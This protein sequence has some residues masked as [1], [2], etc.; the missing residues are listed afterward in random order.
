MDDPVI[1]CVSY[2][3][4]KTCITLGKFLE[5][6][7]ERL[8][9]LLGLAFILVAC[10]TIIRIPGVIDGLLNG[11]GKLRWRWKYVGI[12]QLLI[13]I[14]DLPLIISLPFYILC[15]WR[16]YL[17]NAGIVKHNEFEKYRWEGWEVRGRILKH[18]ILLLF[19]ILS[20]PFAICLTVSWRCIRCFNLFSKCD[21]KEKTVK[22]LIVCQFLHL[23]CDI[24]ALPFVVI[25]MLS[26][27]APIILKKIKKIY[28]A[29]SEVSNNHQ[30]PKMVEL[31]LEEQHKVSNI[32][33]DPEVTQLESEKLEGN[34]SE[35]TPLELEEQIP[36]V[37]QLELQEELQEPNEDVE[38]ANEVD[39]K[40]KVVVIKQTWSLVLD[41]SSVPAMITTIFSWR[42][43]FFLS[44]CTKKFTTRNLSLNKTYSY[45]RWK[46]WQNLVY[47]FMDLPCIVSFF[48]LVVFFPI[49]PWRLVQ[50]LSGFKSRLLVGQDGKEYK[51]SK[52]CQM[53]ERKLLI[54]AY[55]VIACDIA[56]IFLTIAIT[57]SLWR[58]PFLVYDLRKV[59]KE[60]LKADEGTISRQYGFKKSLK[61]WTVCVTNFVLLFADLLCIVIGLIIIGTLWR[62]YSLFSSIR[63]SLSPK[64][65]DDDKEDLRITEN[66][67][68]FTVNGIKIRKNVFKHF[69]FLILDIPALVLCFI[70]I[71]F[72]IKIPAIISVVLGGNFYLEFAVTVYIETAKLFAD[73]VFFFIFI[74]M[75]FT[76]PIAIWVNVLEDKK[77]KKYRLSADMLVH[78]KWLIGQR[79]KKVYE[80]KSLLSMVIKN[81]QAR[82]DI[83]SNPVMQAGLQVDDTSEQ[84]LA[85]VS[86]A[87]TICKYTKKLE[88]VKNTLYE[89]EL[90]DRLMYHVS[91]VVFFENKVA[92]LVGRRFKVEKMFLANPSLI[93]YRRNLELIEKEDSL[94]EKRRVDAVEAL[95]SFKFEQTPLWEKK[96]G[97]REKSRKET[98]KA[99]ISAVTSGNFVTF[100]VCFINTLLLYRAPSM[101]LSIFK[102]PHRRRNI[103]LK[104]LKNYLLDLFMLAKILLI[105]LSVYKVPDLIS[106]LVVSL[107]QKR[108]IQAAR[109][110]V[111]SIP[112]E[113]IHDLFRVLAI[114]FS[115]KSIAYTFSSILFLILMPLSVMVKIYSAMFQNIAVAY[116]FSGLCYA[117]VLSLPFI[118][119]LALP[120]KIGI[121]IAMSGVVAGYMLLLVLIL[122]VFVLIYVK[123]VEKTNFQLKSIDY[124]RINWFN[125]HVYFKLVIEF[126]QLTALVFTVNMTH[127]QHR[128]YL[129]TISKYILLDVYEPVIKF[130][131][132]CAVFV[133]WF[134]IASIPIILEGILMYADKGT[135]SKSHFTWRAFLSFFGSTLFMVIPE[136]GLSFLACD[137]SITK[138]LDKSVSASLIDD[139]NM[140]CWT[141]SHAPYAIFSLFGMMW[142]LLTSTL[143]C[144]TFSD[145][146]NQKIDLQFSPAYTAI[147]NIFKVSIVTVMTLFK[148]SIYSL[149]AALVLVV[150][151]IFVTCVW[152]VLTQTNV[153]NYF[154]LIILKVGL[155]TIVGS[156]ALIIIAVEQF[157][158]TGIVAIYAM[159]G[160]LLVLIIIISLA[161]MSGWGLI[162]SE[163]KK[164]RDEFK[165][166]VLKITAKLKSV[167]ALVVSWSQ[168]QFVFRRMLRHV[169]V[170]HPKDRIFEDKIAEEMGKRIEGKATEEPP[171]PS[172]S[173]LSSF[174]ALPEPP[175]YESILSEKQAELQA[176]SYFVPDA[177]IYL[178][179]F[180]DWMSFDAAKKLE[181]YG[182][183]IADVPD[184]VMELTD[185]QCTGSDLLLLLEQHVKYTSH[186]YEFVKQIGNWRKAVK[187]SNW[188]G[189]LQCT[190]ILDESFDSRFVRPKNG[191]IAQPNESEIISPN[192][193][194][195]TFPMY[196]ELTDVTSIKMKIHK[197]ELEKL[198]LFIPEPWKWVFAKIIPS[199]MPVI[200]RVKDC[201]DGTQPSHFSVDLFKQLNVTIKD[202]DSGGF[203]IARGARIVVPKT[204]N[205]LNLSCENI[206]FSK[207]YLSGSKGPVTKSVD[208]LNAT[209]VGEHWYV[210]V[211][212]NRAKVSKILASLHGLEYG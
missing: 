198:L 131:L 78:V 74:F 13:F 1:A 132:A 84:N 82:E 155:L 201:D 18:F 154:R 64:R 97:F 160:V 187:E 194:Q 204:L 10:C 139:S 177:S 2:V 103:A 94:F 179:P 149:L 192:P 55:A 85:E 140:K 127:F 44:S 99:I 86:I 76:R 121:S 59:R 200:K 77:H 153:A 102:A 61:I 138:E 210:V 207:P 25:L 145:N 109:K 106:A 197:Q 53:H 62:A 15:P 108:S 205:I 80:S 9:D 181:Q 95:K 113:M 48:L 122:I 146:L 184:A 134:F 203:K 162:K 169:R 66:V 173:D 168:V 182:W 206:T 73:I 28:F 175:S 107:L 69:L 212:K 199:D 117:T 65:K 114:L 209:K 144:L 57:V 68:I 133:I 208:S 47:F 8:L 141:N 167:D 176:D 21:K 42:I 34:I 4:K 52:W 180:G 6:L 143:L 202:I 89:E 111:D 35:E 151:L 158:I 92:Y 40:I 171:P 12:W 16:I 196:F 142:Y 56:S 17:V 32:Q 26:W 128:D 118:I 115:W 193:D 31:D 81:S 100:L 129:T 174:D 190:K 27:R 70:H 50:Y 30:A 45:I 137:Y 37:T 150:A 87:N 54:A 36:E 49:I 58:L 98:Q 186:S 33:E 188:A 39:L 124:V 105:C 116:I 38:R 14:L 90:D 3:V 23:V 163:Q 156:F 136:I 75:C 5:F 178:S 195:S 60:T 110:A 148:D 183:M 19:D 170:A 91:Q 83:D 157:E 112:N 166:L 185:A 125:I 88:K 211:G 29:K 63:S 130:S 147:E 104:T 119:P 67:S 126:L 79:K 191:S 46:F 161:S 164:A 135:F 172:Y 152:K 7:G 189:L 120:S 11:G 22:F 159:A 123:S 96:V 20:I 43:V 41:L 165:T 71:P 51:S 93:A 101:F 24:L 72:V